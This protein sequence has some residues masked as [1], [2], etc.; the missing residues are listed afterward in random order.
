MSVRSRFSHAARLSRLVRECSAPRATGKTV[1]RV[2]RATAPW[3]Q[4]ATGRQAVAFREQPS[5]DHPEQPAN[6]AIRTS[7]ADRYR[8]S[9]VSRGI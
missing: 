3:L 2:R 6:T 7:R 5:C 9:T 4:V 1:P 8:S